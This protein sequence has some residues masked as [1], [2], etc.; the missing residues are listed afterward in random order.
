MKNLDKYGQ[1]VLSESGT[2]SD[3]SILLDQFKSHPLLC[4]VLLLVF[5]SS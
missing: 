3:L 4:W 2:L 5:P 1:N